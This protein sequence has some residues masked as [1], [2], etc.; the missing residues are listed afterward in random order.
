MKIK[1]AAR[2]NVKATGS[3]KKKDLTSKKVSKEDPARGLKTLNRKS[4]KPWKKQ[5][6]KNKDTNSDFEEVE[7]EP[8][9]IQVGLKDY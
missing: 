8:E 5:E 6:N 1:V 9:S 7:D 2:K 4:K 3:L